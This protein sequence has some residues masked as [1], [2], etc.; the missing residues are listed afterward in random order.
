VRDKTPDRNVPEEI[1]AYLLALPED[2]RAALQ[3]VREIVHELAPECTERVSYRIAM[4]RLRRDLVALSAHTQHVALHTLSPALAATI[5]EEILRGEL[6]VVIVSGATIHFT[7][8]SPLPREVVERV[9][10]A[11]VEAAG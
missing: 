7:A 4:F 1:D 5:Q 11:R 10:R 8:E 9:V 2:Q 6:P 3:R